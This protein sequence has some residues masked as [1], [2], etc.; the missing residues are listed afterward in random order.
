MTRYLKKP[1]EIE[2]KYFDGTSESAAEIVTWLNEKIPGGT[3]VTGVRKEHI[4]R[5]P[6]EKGRRIALE[7]ETAETPLLE[8]QYIL[9]R[10]NWGLVRSID[11]EYVNS[12]RFEAQYG[13]AP[14][15]S[16]DGD[17]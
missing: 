16:A 5:G 7:L 12:D 13:L 11:V 2:A 3:A 17:S 4:T 9:L 8:G 14:E 15:N 6:Y 1:E 10:T